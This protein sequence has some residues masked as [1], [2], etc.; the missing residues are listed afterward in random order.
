MKSK[1]RKRIKTLRQKVKISYEAKKAAGLYLLLF[2]VIWV[3]LTF[4][5][6]FIP[7]YWRCIGEGSFDNLISISLATFF[8]S[9]RASFLLRFAITFLIAAAV[10][11]RLWFMRTQKNKDIMGSERLGRKEDLKAQSHI[12]SVNV[13]HIEKAEGMGLPV[14]R[15]GNR[16]YYDTSTTNSLIAGTTRS[17]KSQFFVMWLVYNIANALNKQHMVI[18]DPKGEI[19]SYTYPTL[20]KNDY[21]VHIINLRDTNMSEFWNAFQ[22]IIDDYVEMRETDSDDLSKINVKIATLTLLF[23]QND[24]S[25]P[26]WPQSAQA[27]F[28]AIILLLLELAYDNN[29]LEKLNLYSLYTFFVEFVG[30]EEKWKSSA[31]ANVF[32]EHIA[33]TEL[34]ESLPAGS[35][36][37]NAYATVKLAKGEMLSSILATLSSNITM[38]GEDVGIQKLTSKN[39]INIK[40]LLSD[41]KPCAI[42]LIV[43]DNNPS[44]HSLASLFITLCYEVLVDYTSNPKLCPKRK[45][46]TRVNFILDEFGNMPTIPNLWNIITVCLGRN[47]LF[48][49]FVQDIP[50][51]EQKYGIGAKTINSNCGN[52]VYVYS[53]DPE[54]NEYFSKILGDKTGEY[55]T[56]N[57]AITAF[58]LDQQPP[59]Y[60]ARRLKTPNELARLEMGEIL[61]KPQRMYGFITK[62]NPFYD[63]TKDPEVNIDK[64][65]PERNVVLKDTLFNLWYGWQIYFD[66]K[67]RY[68]YNS[69]EDTIA[70]EI[71]E[72]KKKLGLPYKKNLIPA[73]TLMIF[74][75]TI[76]DPSEFISQRAERKIILMDG[77]YN[78][79][80][81]TVIDIRQDGDELT[82]QCDEIKKL[83]ASYVNLIFYNRQAVSLVSPLILNEVT[84]KQNIISITDDDKVYEYSGLRN[85]TIES[86]CKQFN[87]NPANDIET[88]QALL[89]FAYQMNDINDE[90]DKCPS[91]TATDYEENS[92][93]QEF[94]APVD[95]VSVDEEDPDDFG[96]DEEFTPKAKREIPKYNITITGIDVLLYLIAAKTENE[97]YNLIELGAETEVIN[98][99]YTTVSH[100][101]VITADE[102][103]VLV[104]YVCNQIKE[105]TVINENKK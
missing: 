58:C 45:L 33:L 67:L 93:E 68:D 63:F 18:N 78:V 20:K 82:E 7:S 66:R 77:K 14:A 43:P 95:F 30:Y 12:Q 38:F 51:I 79:V 76:K 98:L 47:I 96:G 28:K 3:V 60:T 56:Y 64:L 100:T 48:Y 31:S 2:A 92:D 81:E 1:T 94:T 46:N 17:G 9:D 84:E 80:I 75:K 23:T 32:T 22:N 91:I 24:K 5:M 35:A 59:A 10:F 55:E 21:E 29:E 6:N 105:R 50:Q 11:A 87:A 70:D 25:D 52:L 19:L 103:N 42:F 27:L 97:I 44:R 74:V 41:E 65:L 34:F 104:T 26:I 89:A 16:L 85:I 8:I 83:I 39:E 53:S 49:L 4:L 57:G 99:I 73:D 13:N 37:K 71:V 90:A 69:N 54:T 101:E 15:Y 40:A 61:V 102:A 72:M 62:F 88:A 86:I 36:A